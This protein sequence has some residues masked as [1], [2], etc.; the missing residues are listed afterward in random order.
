MNRLWMF[1]VGCIA[2]GFAAGLLAASAPRMIVTP[3]EAA[4]FKLL[5]PARPDGPRI[6]VLRG[7]PDTGPSTMLMKF[8]KG[9]GRMHIHSSDYDLV[10]ISG[11]MKHWTPAES[12]ATAKVLRP[13]SYW[14]QP[15]NQPHVDSC[16]S[17]ECLMYVQW[18]GKRDSRAAET[19]AK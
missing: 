5:N 17:E 9:E 10:V 7:D 2:L 19:D 1:A 6:A 13:G 14:Y 3:V 12:A 18:Q 8:G 4:E 15:G 16:L 11:E